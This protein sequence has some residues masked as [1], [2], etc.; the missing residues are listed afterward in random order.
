MSKAKT[1]S[2]ASGPWVVMKTQGQ[3][4]Q[5]GGYVTIIT[6]VNNHGEIVHTYADPDNTNY[7]RWEE[8]I[9]LNERGWGVILDDLR[10]KVKEGSILTRNKTTEPLINAD[11]KVRA[12]LIQKNK[13]QILDELAEVLEL[14]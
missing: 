1:T 13:Q 7:K 6:M 5:Y 12:I 14:Q 11:S 4:S 8:V 10:Y 2:T 3:N 9:E